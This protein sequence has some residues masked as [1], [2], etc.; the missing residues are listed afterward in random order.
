MRKPIQ[1]GEKFYKSKKE[2][3][4]HYKTILNLY[5][6]DE[7]L[8][9]DDFNDLLDLIIYDEEFDEGNSDEISSQVIDVGEDL[10][11]NE[12]EEEEEILIQDIKIGRSSFNTKFFELLYS[13][14][15]TEFFSYLLVINRPK[16]DKE[17]LLRRACRN[18]VFKDITAVK[19]QYFKDNTQGGGYVKCQETGDL[20][21]WDD[22]VVDHRQPNTL[23]MI[24]ERFKE[25]HQIDIKDLEFIVDDNNQILFQDELLTQKFRNYHRDKANLRVVKKECNSS[26]T[27][28]ARVKQSN[29]DLKI[30]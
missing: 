8:N 19:Q 26:R 20:C 11:E 10:V 22:L 1:I 7:V 23:S 9:D 12:I 4:L 15:T 3:L 6:F 21:K 30:K 14:L 13:D 25:L 16:V 2:A 17:N 18:A 5:D 27:A 24:I 29:K 28:M